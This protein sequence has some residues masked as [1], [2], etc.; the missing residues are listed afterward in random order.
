MT[1]L[2]IN[3]NEKNELYIEWQGKKLSY[4]HEEKWMNDEADIFDM[5]PAARAG[6]SKRVDSFVIGNYKNEIISDSDNLA[7][8]FEFYVDDADDKNFKIVMKYYLPRGGVHEVV[9]N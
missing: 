5:N 8:A 4:A 9:F 1:K 6:Y 2:E 3:V 7:Q